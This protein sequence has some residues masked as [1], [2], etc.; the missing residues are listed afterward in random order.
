MKNVICMKP[1]HFVDIMTSFSAEDIIFR[2]GPHGHAVHTFSERIRQVS[3]TI[4]VVLLWTVTSFA[5]ESSGL[6]ASTV[7]GRMD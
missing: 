3:E 4:L 1:R 6:N 2:P 5:A 7:T